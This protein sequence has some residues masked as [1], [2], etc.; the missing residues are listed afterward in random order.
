MSESVPTYIQ[1]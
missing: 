1:I